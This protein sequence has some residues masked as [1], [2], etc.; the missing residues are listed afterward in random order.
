MQLTFLDKAT[1]YTPLNMHQYEGTILP[2]QKISTDTAT[3]NIQDT[4]TQNPLYLSVALDQNQTASGRVWLEQRWNEE[5]LDAEKYE[6]HAEKQVL[7]FR[8]QN[9]GSVKSGAVFT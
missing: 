4:M 6:I 3:T 5:D 9:S 1:H 8:Q 2:F 7:A